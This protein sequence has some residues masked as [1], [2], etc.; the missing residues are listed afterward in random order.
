MLIAQITDLHLTRAGK[1]AY[2]V[3]DT[4]ALLER[5]VARL[6]ALEPRP[7]L[8]LVTGDLTYD[9]G[10]DEYARLLALM[11]P[12]PVPW[13]AIPGNHDRRQPMR[14]ALPKANCPT[15]DGPPGRLCWAVEDLPVRIL[16]LDTLVEGQSGGEVGPAQLAWLEAKLA[17][18]PGRPALVLMHHPPVPTGIGHMDRIACSDAAALGAL[19]A[20]H[21]QLERVLCGHVH[22]PIQWRW[23]GTLVSAAPSV[24]HQVRLDLRPGAPSGFDLEPPAFHLHLWLEGTGLVTHHAYVA[25]APGPYPF[26][27]A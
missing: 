12:L 23:N 24:A 22:R 10:E 9:G 4:G 14:A 21:P 27:D 5:A 15:G 3:V 13:L 16:A 17:A 25:A 7:D 11:A 1:L 2:G 20:R 18:A 6:A 19:V 8:V 26:R